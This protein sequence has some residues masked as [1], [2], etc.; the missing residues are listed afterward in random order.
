MDKRT[1]NEAKLRHRI[2]SKRAFSKPGGEHADRAAW[3]HGGRDPLVTADATRARFEVLCGAR[4]A[5]TLYQYSA[6]L[7]LALSPE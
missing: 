6:S 3:L 5:V 7:W 2:G 1:Q 4:E